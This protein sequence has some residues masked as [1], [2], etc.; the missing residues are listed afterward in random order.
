MVRTLPYHDA[1]SIR[2]AYE[3]RALLQLHKELEEAS[4]TSGAS[5]IQTFARITI[6]LLKPALLNGWLFTA[7][8]VSKVVGTV[9]MIYSNESVVISLLV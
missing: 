9:I 1:P 3:E 2:N 5:W 6:P 8:I 4:Y 7:I